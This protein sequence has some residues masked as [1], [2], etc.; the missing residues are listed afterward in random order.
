MLFRHNERKK[1]IEVYKLLPCGEVNLI[2]L[3][4]GNIHSINGEKIF[5]PKEGA[6]LT[7]KNLLD[8]YYFIKG[9]ELKNFE[10]LD[11][12]KEIKK[13]DA[14]LSDEHIIALKNALNIL[15]ENE[16]TFEDFFR[17]TYT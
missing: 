8:I 5:V 3:K 9:E 17:Q 10:F 7:S 4:I 6:K 15:I 13:L 2:K 16:I 14:V 1:R 11:N 12:L